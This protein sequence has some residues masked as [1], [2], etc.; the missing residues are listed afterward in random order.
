MIQA[1]HAQSDSMRPAPPPMDH[2]RPFARQFSADPRR[3]DD[4]FLNRLM[5]EVM[6]D[7][8]LIDVGAGGGR[9]ALPLALHCK[10]VTA[11]EPSP[12]M[13]EVL[14]GGAKAHHV[15]NISLVPSD[16]LEVQVEPADQVLCVHVLYTIQD[17]GGFIRKLQDHARAQVMVVMYGAPPQSQNYPLWEKV[18]G[19]PRL[20]L[21]SVPEFRE[22]L[23]DLG[24]EAREEPLA[25][26]PARGFD[27]MEQAL[28]QISGRL[29]LGEDD[30]KRDML[31]R[32]L[33]DEL[34][35]TDGVYRIRG[36]VPLQPWLIRWAGSASG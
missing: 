8:T 15:E 34:E 2:W 27:S 26:Q 6:A 14:T 7:Q 13:G 22:V 24:I 28:D 1:E 20:P 35:E 10:H 36:A 18:H 30:P 16:W 17:I 19:T 23:R 25:A 5:D 29:F 12:A 32:M 11:V 4:A 9:L 33:P 31:T 3:S 21:P